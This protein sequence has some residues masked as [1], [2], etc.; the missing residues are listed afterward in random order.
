M[1]YLVLL[2]LAP[3]VLLFSNCKQTEAK[4]DVSFAKQTFESLARGDSSA[5][6]NIDWETLNSSGVSVGKGYVALPN[7]AEKQSFQNSFVTQFA[8]SF[9]DSGG[10]LDN[11]TNWRVISH[12][13]ISTEVGADSTAGQLVLTVSERN[14][15]E[16]LSAI[17][18][19]K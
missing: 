10:N 1:K 18:V 16:R 9:R 17:Q 3:L 14:G 19:V 7:D 12:N 4:G 5:I 15:V 6:P 2:V 13:D 8:A 11:F